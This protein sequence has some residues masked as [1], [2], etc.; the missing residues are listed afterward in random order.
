MKIRVIPFN[1]DKKRHKH[2]RNKR[3][4]D[5]QKPGIIEADIAHSSIPPNPPATERL[6]L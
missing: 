3:Q 1:G 2:N 6:S 5:K 4:C